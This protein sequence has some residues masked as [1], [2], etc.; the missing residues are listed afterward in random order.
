MLI[1]FRIPPDRITFVP[2]PFSCSFWPSLL[3]DTIP[4][5]EFKEPVIPTKE[6]Y[7][8]LHHL[9]WDLVPMIEKRKEQLRGS[10]K[11]DE[12]GDEN[13]DIDNQA[14]LPKFSS[15]LLNNC[16]DDLV[17]MLRLACARNL[18]RAFI[19]ENTVADWKSSDR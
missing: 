13:G 16:T 6:T 18:A 7:T 12:N 1:V 11:M 10:R 9:E 14:L 3:A 5:L 4:L 15:N 17:K 2:I 8:I 19:I